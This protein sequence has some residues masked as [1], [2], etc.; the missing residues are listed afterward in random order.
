MFS[1]SLFASLHRLELN[2][3]CAFP[4]QNVS[5]NVST[6][7]RSSLCW[8]MLGT[9]LRKG[10]IETM[11][12]ES[13]WNGTKAR[14]E[15]HNG[16]TILESKLFNKSCCFLLFFVFDLHIDVRDGSSTSY[17]SFVTCDQKN[18]STASGVTMCMAMVCSACW[19]TMDT[20]WPSKSAISFPPMQTPAHAVELSQ[21]QF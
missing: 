16:C 11:A 18:F 1:H 13:E 14:L 8:S 5:K 20:S 4:K 21:F 17:I 7:I 19:E 10:P 9:S 3:F 2:V 15:W 6:S 12:Y